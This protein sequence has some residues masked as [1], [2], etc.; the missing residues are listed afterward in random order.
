M[1]E[2]IL[3]IILYILFIIFLWK[4]VG[5]PLI[6]KWNGSI[7][8]IYLI[9]LILLLPCIYFAYQH[10]LYVFY[11]PEVPS[12]KL[13]YIVTL[14]GRFFL[15]PHIFTTVFTIEYSKYLKTKSFPLTETALFLVQLLLY[16]ICL[17]GMERMFGDVF[18][19]AM[20]V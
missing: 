15:L 9:N 4:K 19:A 12:L 10:S 3:L 11:Q 14:I 6:R 8:F 2:V 5:L 20:S 18:M 13:L 7:R 17:L 16:I 1:P